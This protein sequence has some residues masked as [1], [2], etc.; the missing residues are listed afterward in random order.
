[1]ADPNELDWHPIAA[2]LYVLHLDRPALAWEY[3]RRN[4]E[5]RTDWRRHR[6][7]PQ[8]AAQHWGLR[9]LEDP[10]YDAR[11]AHPDWFPTSATVPTLSLHPDIDPA[12]DAQAF[13]LWTLPG[14]KQLHYDGRRLRLAVHL[15]AKDVRLTLSPELEDG[16]AY[17]YSVAALAGADHA[18]GRRHRAL[19]NALPRLDQ[20]ADAQA[21]AR[22]RPSPGALLDLHTL[23][24][25]DG[26][27]AHASLRDVAHA[28]YGAAAVAAGWHA[29]GD[30]RA[31]V[32]RL[33]RRGDALMRGGYRRLL[34]N[35]A[36]EQGRSAPSKNVPAQDDRLS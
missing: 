13:H 10:I 32:R 34:Q 27:L 22:E 7:D 4:P 30:L 35:E 21:L 36:F 14:H 16:M 33:V 5:Y 24:A 25:L 17:A 9:L 11:D 8:Q 12:P 19:Q 18:P 15:P 2:Y 6:H 20:N 29:D 23:Q 31:K 1:M 28:L 26:T 3:L